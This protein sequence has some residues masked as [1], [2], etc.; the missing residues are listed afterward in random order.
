MANGKENTSAASDSSTEK[1]SG[2]QLSNGVK[3]ANAINN[4][5]GDIPED[6]GGAF[7][8]AATQFE[9][10]GAVFA[11]A[12]HSFN[13][14]CTLSDTTKKYLEKKIEVLEV[15]LITA[16][17]EKDEAVREAAELRK[18]QILHEKE[19]TKAKA[20]HVEHVRKVKENLTAEHKKEIERLNA[21]LEREKAEFKRTI[22]V[23]KEL[24]QKNQQL[25]VEKNALLKKVE[26]TNVMAKE[27][28]SMQQEI[29]DIKKNLAITTRK[30]LVAEVQLDQEVQTTKNLE[31]KNAVLESSYMSAVNKVEG[32]DK[33]VADLKSEVADLVSEVNLRV[34]KNRIRDEKERFAVWQL[35]KTR[36]KVKSLEIDRDAKAPLVQ[37][38]IQIRQRYME[39]ESA[40]GISDVWIVRR[41]NTAAHERNGAADSAIF[42]LGLWNWDDHG[43]KFEDIYGSDIEG[44]TKAS[45]NWTRFVKAR[46]EYLFLIDTLMA[47]DK[48]SRAEELHDYLRLV[49]LND[50]RFDPAWDDAVEKFLDEF[51]SLVAEAQGIEDAREVIRKFS[52]ILKELTD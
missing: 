14:G 7:K 50:G 49:G 10:M 36:K 48:F 24:R 18:E 45:E 44:Y 42:K 2:Y 35:E 25:I 6:P 3:L 23:P 27:F 22:D 17:K 37:I 51:E 39:Q 26:G 31:S 21:N 8:S 4:G 47:Q 9:N 29:V 33:Q 40:G 5:L 38:G 16:N 46:N 52:L 1:S 13:L 34:E 28:G 19:L 20:D 41:G 43:Q 15:Q 12:M 11:Q 30:L 32:Q